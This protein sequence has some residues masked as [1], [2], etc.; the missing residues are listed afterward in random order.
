VNANGSG[1]RRGHTRAEGMPVWSPNGKRLAFYFG[2]PRSRL[3]LMDA[4]GGDL[5]PLTRNFPYSCFWLSWSPNGRRIAYTLND[6]C[7]GGM[8]VR[9]VGLDGRGDRRLV[10]GEGHWDPVWSPN[11]TKILY[12]SY[13]VR[14]KTKLF[15]TD[16]AGRRR[17][18]LTRTPARSTIGLPMRPTAAWSR[19]GTR[20]YFVGEDAVLR[21]M[22]QD[23][24]GVRKL[25]PKLSV[26][27]FELS[28]S[29]RQ[30]ALAGVETAGTRDIYVL[31]ANGRNLRK[32]THGA[33]VMNEDP[34]WSPNGRWLVF[35]RRKQYAAQ[36][37]LYV[38]DASGRDARRLTRT[39]L[40]E[41]APAWRPT[42]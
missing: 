29:G 14:L 13:D 15:I 18:G 16:A 31:R 35:T 4:K 10:P 7:G 20:I 36:A 27:D 39:P 34:R 8:S 22:R 32:L 25:V 33:G 5:R 1:L 21:V 11:G 24:S 42:S 26:R 41:V 37:D 30:V 2:D 12:S 9:V 23:G 6:D 40:D 19:D 38:M 17:H 3:Y 28:P